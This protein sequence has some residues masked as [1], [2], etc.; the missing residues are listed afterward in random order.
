MHPELASI[1]VALGAARKFTIGPW[2]AGPDPGR[3]HRDA[4]SISSEIVGSAAR[5]TSWNGRNWCQLNRAT[6]HGARS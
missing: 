1:A 2:I 6:G 4:G 3:D 5:A